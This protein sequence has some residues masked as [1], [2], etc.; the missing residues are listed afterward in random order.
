MYSVYI[1]DDEVWLVDSLE[2][3]LERMELDIEVVGKE[4]SSLNAYDDIIRLKPDIVFTDI[5]M[6]ELDGLELMERVGEKSPA[7][8][9]IIISGFADFEYARTAM[10]NKAV[11]YCLKPFEED[12]IKKALE[13]AMALCR[14][15]KILTSMEQGRKADGEEVERSS[16]ETFLM[17]EDYIRNHFKENIGLQD[18]ADRFFFSA[19]Y[20]SILFKKESGMNFTTYMNKLSVD[21]ACELLK[22]TSLPINEISEMSGVSSYYYFCRIFKKAK[23][24]TPTEYREQN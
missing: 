10:K 5:K 1:V 8:V 16:S 18:V 23:G 22:N 3:L 24:I 12:D 20:L 15:R 7:T 6:P 2:I 11:S 17:I 4:T 19:A 9:F 13:S 21:Y 14:D